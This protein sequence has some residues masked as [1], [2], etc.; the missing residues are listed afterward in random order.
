MSLPT[1]ST[2]YQVKTNQ[3]IVGMGAAATTNQIYALY[4]I[5]SSLTDAVTFTTSA[6]VKGSGNT[7]AGAMD[8][9]DRWSSAASMTLAASPWWI[10][11][12]FPGLSC[13]LCISY[14]N[15][16]TFTARVGMSVG[17]LY[18][19][20]SSSAIPTATDEVIVYNAAS[21][22]GLPYNVIN[23]NNDQVLHHSQ[24][25]DGTA[26]N[27]VLCSNYAAYTFLRLGRV[28]S[29]V[30]NWTTATVASLTTACTYAA[31]STAA[32][33]VSRIGTTNVTANWT[34]EGYGSTPIHSALNVPD[35]DTTYW[36]MPPVGLWCPTTGKRGRKGLVQDVWWAQAGG[37]AGFVSP[38]D[39][40]L[41]AQFG[42][43]MIPWN[44]AAAPTPA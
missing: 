37:V 38:Y 42:D 39:T 11:L 34:A 20:G 9:V 22:A 17:K 18:T 43:V 1:P 2:T 32:A 14:N 6:L 29:A 44:G 33:S 19:G 27:L 15:T 30:T 24:A 16:S 23:A 12:E 40:R 26:V 8:S 21:A 36:M 10:V 13:Q 4:Q 25:N 7:S 5:K 41:F 3:R 35:D 28:L 31:L